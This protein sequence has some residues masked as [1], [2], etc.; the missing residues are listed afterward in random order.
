MRTII[1]KRDSPNRQKTFLSVVHVNRLR[2]FAVKVN[3][4]RGKDKQELINN[5]VKSGKVRLVVNSK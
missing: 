4:R 2:Q 1:D 3:V 5:L